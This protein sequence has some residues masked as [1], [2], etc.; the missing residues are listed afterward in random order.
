[1]EL[2]YGQLYDLL[3]SEKYRYKV[4]LDS[5][6]RLWLYR[7]EQSM[8]SRRYQKK[9][10]VSVKNLEGESLAKYQMNENLVPFLE[11]RGTK[12]INNLLSLLKSKGVYLEA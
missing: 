3:V 2:H 11:S 7:C 8:T 12:T 4:K 1:M 6:S 5:V 9:V 10:S